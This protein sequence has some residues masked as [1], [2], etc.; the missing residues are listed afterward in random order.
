MAHFNAFVILQSRPLDAERA[1]AEATEYHVSTDLLFYVSRVIG[2]VSPDE[3]AQAVAE[4]KRACV[5][6]SGEKSWSRDPWDREHCGSGPL[7]SE[8]A[9]AALRAAAFILEVNCRA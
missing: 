3:A 6:M 4:Y 2:E 1:L 8:D 7:P 5:V 9:I